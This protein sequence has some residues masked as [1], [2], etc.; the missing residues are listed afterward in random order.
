LG[1]K[2]NQCKQL[3]ESSLSCLLTNSKIPS[4]QKNLNSELKDLKNNL[5]R[6]ME[7]QEE[8]MSEIIQ[9]IKTM[10]EDFEQ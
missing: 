10:N 2:S 7:K 1:G 8:Q 9:V 6:Q 4:T 3:T 5:E